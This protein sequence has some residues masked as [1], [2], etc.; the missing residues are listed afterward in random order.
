MPTA[1]PPTTRKTTINQMLVPMPVTTALIRNSAAAS[2]ITHS[3][4]IASA[5]RPAVSAPTAAPSSAEATAKPRVASLIAN[6]SCRAL[7]APLITALS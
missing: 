1:T 2:F 3:R 6:S 7:T 5:R 4:P